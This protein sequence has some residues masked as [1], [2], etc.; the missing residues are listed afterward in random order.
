MRFRFFS[1]TYDL[2]VASLISSSNGG[3]SRD[4]IWGAVL[5]GQLS[6]WG[7]VRA[8]NRGMTCKVSWEASPRPETTEM[9]TLLMECNSYAANQ[10]EI[11]MMTTGHFKVMGSQ[12]NCKLLI[13]LLTNSP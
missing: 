8:K 2:R 10:D 4:E 12:I 1:V 3:R 9:D 6:A 7:D 11:I 5:S 13:G